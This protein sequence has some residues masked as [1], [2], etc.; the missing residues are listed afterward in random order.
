MWRARW[1]GENP[2]FLRLTGILSID[3]LLLSSSR[4]P[5]YRYFYHL[6]FFLR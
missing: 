1:W 5:A 2:A 4:P 6:L 3:L